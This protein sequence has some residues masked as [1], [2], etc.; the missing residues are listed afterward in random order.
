MHQLPVRW[1]KFPVVPC[2]DLALQIVVS[3]DVRPELH[4]L[5]VRVSSHRRLPVGAIVA[6]ILHSN[7]AR[8]LLNAQLR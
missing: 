5:L 8:E 6:A 2:D 3:L 4:E 1:I 7:T